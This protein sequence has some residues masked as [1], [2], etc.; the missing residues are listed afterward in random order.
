[1]SRKKGLKA[2]DLRANQLQHEHKD[3]QVYRSAA[4]HSLV[5][6]TCI[7]EDE[8][9][10]EQIKSV[11]YETYKVAKQ[12]NSSS[13]LYT[14]K[15]LVENHIRKELSKFVAMPVPI[16]V[17]KRFLVRIGSDPNFLLLWSN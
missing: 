16:S 10:L 14:K 2:E 15:G 3:A 9:I 17:T 7:T 13:Y 4:S 6:V 8:V 5:D 12:H 11:K 1:M